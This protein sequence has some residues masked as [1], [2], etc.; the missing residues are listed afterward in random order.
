MSDSEAAKE[1]CTGTVFTDESG[2]DEALIYNMRLMAFLAGCQ[3]VRNEE[4]W[5]KY[6]EEKPEDRDQVWCCDA[7]KGTAWQAGLFGDR[8]MNINNEE[9]RAPTHWMPITLPE[10]KEPKL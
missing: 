7:V 8:W 2:N 1:Y 4:R 6:P 9:K 3:H 5:R 10:T